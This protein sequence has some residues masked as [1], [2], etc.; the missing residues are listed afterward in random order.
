MTLKPTITSIDRLMPLAFE[1]YLPS[2]FDNGFTIVEKL[3]LVI[4]QLNR[5]GL[6]T[7]DVVDRW[8]E[9]MDIIEND[10]LQDYI[11]EKMD[12]WLNDG[13]IE[14]ILNDL[15]IENYATIEWVKQQLTPIDLI[16]INLD[17]TYIDGTKISDS[18]YQFK[19][20]PNA[21][22]FLQNKAIKPKKAVI[23]YVGSGY[24]KW[25]GQV[26]IKNYDASYM[27]IKGNFEID[28][29][30]LLECFAVPSSPT[31]YEVVPALYGKMAN[32]PYLT[33]EFKMIPVP[34]ALEINNMD[35]C[36]NCQGSLA[37][38]KFTFAMLDNSDMV[39]ISAEVTVKD[40]PLAGFA[41]FNG[42]HLTA[43]GASVYNIGNRSTLV[44]GTADVN[45]KG[46]G[47]L[48][49]NSTLSANLS[50]ADYCGGTGWNI[51]QAS[52]ADLDGS[53]SLDCG[54][55][56]LLVTG[57]SNASFKGG[58]IDRVLDDNIVAYAG[59][60][61]D[62]RDS[63]IGGNANSRNYGLI[64]TMSSKINFSGGTLSGCQY[65]VMANRNSQV[66][67]T[68]AS[69]SNYPQT[70]VESDSVRSAQGSMVI[71]TSATINN[72]SS[73]DACTA[74]HG[75]R[76]IVNLATINAGANG[77]TAIMAYDGD[78]FG[79]NAIISGGNNNT[80]LASRGGKIDLFQSQITG[81]NQTDNECVHAY[82]G[83]IQVN[84][85]TITNAWRAMVATR[86]GSIIASYGE[87]HSSDLGVLAYSADV[88]IS[89]SN[90]YS[91]VQATMGGRLRATNASFK[92]NQAEMVQCYN[93][94]NVHL[95]ESFLS[96]GSP[97]TR[98]NVNLDT[99]TVTAQ[100]IIYYDTALTA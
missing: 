5:I 26:V 73:G 6:I 41:A 37:D 40:F 45:G 46:D 92:I 2:A 50:H 71:V 33:G 20:I 68:E 75:G 3:N 9:L 10:E 4:E 51:T 57:A 95:N 88:D 77:K 96:D 65:G 52:T 32:L 21:V 35:T 49:V 24:Y 89:G 61:I 27:T 90:I 12:E 64:A 83:Q 85:C 31:P 8:N 69:I 74:E 25:A 84:E 97:L 19:S 81:V 78:V 76:L 29:T 60:Q 22:T 34:T 7:N 43:H 23:Q 15:L 44:S 72:Q 99:N 94:S 91:K 39:C 87:F 38:N 80:I 63:F 48:I 58:S 36:Q 70:T 14:K 62:A 59:S 53:Q 67:C 55:H 17:N 13:T 11:N 28:P 30:S 79:Q 18:E 1:K 42:S 100:G 56:G 82:G 86:G 98:T 16:T 47:F 66:D 93:G 54:H